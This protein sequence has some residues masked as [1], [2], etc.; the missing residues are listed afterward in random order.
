MKTVVATLR[1]HCRVVSL[2]H[3]VVASGGYTWTT[4]NRKAFV[5]L[6][7]GLK[8]HQLPVKLVIVSKG[9]STPAYTTYGVSCSKCHRQRHRR[10]TCPLQINGGSHQDTRQ[11]PVSRPPSSKPMPSNNSA[12]SAPA[13]DLSASIK[14]TLST[15][16]SPV[17]P[18]PGVNI[19]VHPQET[20][21]PEPPVPAPS[22]SQL[23][24]RPEPSLAIIEPTAAPKKTTHNKTASS[25]QS[26]TSMTQP[27][28]PLQESQ[29][30]IGRVE[31]IFE[32]MNADSFLSPLYEEISMAA[33]LQKID[34]DPEL[35]TLKIVDI[36]TA[37]IEMYGDI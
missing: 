36:V 7:E 22:T 10:T 29:I 21:T 16:S 8:L 26:S 12:L 1:P 11:V 30:L 20:T 24:P 13:A 17:A 15:P 2:T 37:V 19:P 28:Q 33:A 4:G 3:E 18:S 9:E 6:N 5:L 23:L 14:Q 35:Y 31:G 27:M 32:P 34:M 25:I